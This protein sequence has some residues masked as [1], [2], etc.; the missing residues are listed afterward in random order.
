[1]MRG[2]DTATL[3]ARALAASAT[4][5]GLNVAVEERGAKRWHSA[6]FSGHKHALALT[7]L[8]GG[9]DAKAWLAGL[10]GLDVRLPGELLAG[11]SIVEEGDSASGCRAEVEALTVELA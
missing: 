10:A 6:T 4:L 7:A 8:P 1:M 11:I 2:P 5:H 9:S 3:L